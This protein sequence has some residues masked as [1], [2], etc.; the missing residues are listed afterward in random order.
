MECLP[1]YGT[2]YNIYITILALFQGL[3]KDGEAA[4]LCLNTR[5]AECREF[6][7]GVG[8]MGSLGML[9]TLF[10]TRLFFPI[11]SPP[12]S[13]EMCI[14]S[15]PFRQGKKLALSRCQL[16]RPRESEDSQPRWSL[17]SCLV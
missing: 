17:H 11:L 10:S 13:G 3:S 8:G 5:Y 14:F 7:A 12:S 15:T 6:G 1:E 9:A 16:D 2:L 4:N